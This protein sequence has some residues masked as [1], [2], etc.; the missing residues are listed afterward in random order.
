MNAQA[1]GFQSLILSQYYAS[2]LQFR[3]SKAEAI[4]TVVN[5]VKN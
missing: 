4:A 5:Y 3:L 2:K 1:S